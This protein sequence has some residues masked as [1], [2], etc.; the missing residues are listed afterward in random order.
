MRNKFKAIRTR[1][2]SSKL[3]AAGYDLLKMREMAGEIKDIKCQQAVTLIERNG[4]SIRWKIDF[5]FWHIPTDQ[6]EYAEIK[7][8]ET[9]DYKIKLKLYKMDPPA[10]LT[11][12]KGTYQRLYIVERVEKDGRER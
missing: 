9:E 3:E 6:L 12:Y 4:H 2:F 8:V 10:P 7:G 11:I 1:G 5:S